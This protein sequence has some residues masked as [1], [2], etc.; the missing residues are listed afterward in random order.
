M[1]EE[2]TEGERGVISLPVESVLGEEEAG[3]LAVVAAAEVSGGRAAVGGG[4]AGASSAEES[5]LAPEGFE[6]TRQVVVQQAGSTETKLRGPDDFDNPTDD[7]NGRTSSKKT[8]MTLRVRTLRAGGRGIGKPR[9]QR[10]RQ[11]IPGVLIT[12]TDSSPEKLCRKRSG[13]S[14]KIQ[15]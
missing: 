11:V 13:R 5:H 2:A 12:L 6:A 9:L 1:K 15:Q 10:N 3:E 7:A 4:G 8:D 14:G